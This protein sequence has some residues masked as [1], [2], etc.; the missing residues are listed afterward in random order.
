M[1]VVPLEGAVSP[2]INPIRFGWQN[3]TPCHHYG[4]TVRNYWLFHYVI[5]GKGIYCVGEKTYQVT[6]G[7]LFVIEPGTLTYYEADQEDPWHYI[8]IG[9]ECE[10]EIPFFP[11][12]V[13]RCPA[14]F[15]IFEK[16]K[17]CEKF[18][19]HQKAH[20]CEGLWNLFRLWKEEEK[21]G[22]LIERALGIFH[23]NYSEGITVEQTARSLHLDRSYFSS[24]FKKRMGVSPARYLMQLRMD[25]AKS[26]LASGNSVS[27]TAASVG[28][29]DIYIFSKMFKRFFGVSPKKYTKEFAKKP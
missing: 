4:P 23:A 10:G 15:S 6:K 8:W 28:Y 11:T 29:S 21:K 3:C 26:L 5:S 16:M 1:H 22:D 12:P 24:L 7:C 27:V 17:E 9:F 18:K 19:T 2:R 20:L 13:L 14:A 25:A